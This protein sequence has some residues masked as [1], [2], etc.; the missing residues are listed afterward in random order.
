MCTCYACVY[1]TISL[2]AIFIG[3][4]AVTAFSNEKNVV[5]VLCVDGSCADALAKF[6]QVVR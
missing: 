3:I 1:I 6:S 5:A 4:M 2:H